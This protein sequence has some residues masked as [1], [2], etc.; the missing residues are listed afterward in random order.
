VSAPSVGS[1]GHGSRQ[2]SVGGIIVCSERR[3]LERALDFGVAFL[4]ATD[5]HAC[6][7][8]I[9]SSAPLHSLLPFRLRIDALH[10]RTDGHEIFLFPDI[11]EDED[12]DDDV[13][14]GHYTRE[15][16]ESAKAQKVLADK[17]LR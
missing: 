6:Q 3:E 7:P 1:V 10:A 2:H 13:R 12:E 14:A 8:E 5:F 4:P 17:S 11:G 9:P 15:A 16:R